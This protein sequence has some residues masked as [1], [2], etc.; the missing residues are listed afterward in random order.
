MHNERARAKQIKKSARILHRQEKW[1]GC[2]CFLKSKCRDK[3]LVPD[4]TSQCALH[5]VTMSKFIINQMSALLT[6]FVPAFQRRGLLSGATALN[7]R[8][9]WKKTHTF[10]VA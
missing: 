9:H 3:I 1:L 7:G 2:L 8:I 4:I 5:Y 10:D 6:K